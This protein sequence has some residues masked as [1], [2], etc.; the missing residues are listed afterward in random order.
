MTESE[1][2]TC[3]DPNELLRFLGRS[4]SERKRRLFA[5]ACCHHIWS[6]MT[7][8]CGRRAVQTSERYADGRATK[9]EL[10]TAFSAADR[11]QD[12]GRVRQWH[13]FD[14]A[15]LSAH[16]ETRGL[17]DGTATAAAMAN[18]W[19]G[20]AE[21]AWKKMTDEQAYQCLLLRDIFGN[22]FRAVHCAEQWLTAAVVDLASEIYDRR[23]FNHMPALGDRL[24]EAGCS[25]SD[26][27]DHT[28]EPTPHVR[29]C[30]VLDLTMRRS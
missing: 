8:R 5:V 1:W 23:S 3:T 10:E 20:S 12:H 27:L 21:E 6:N 18:I 26:I 28:R 16:P 30:W 15:R 25:H 17:A 4:A 9:E 11:A 13:A 24:M 22:P 14:A 7:D 2:L 29:G 19:G